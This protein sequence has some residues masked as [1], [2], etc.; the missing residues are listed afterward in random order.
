MSLDQ[1]IA[2]IENQILNPII[3]LLFVLATI[4]FMW[5]VI[6]YVITADPG[7]REKGKG[8]MI[9]GIIGMTI[10]ASA[11]GIVRIICDFFDTCGKVF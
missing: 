8:V 3:G 10:M 5:G 4:V 7:K 9:Y 1:L 2:K 11:W 6:Q